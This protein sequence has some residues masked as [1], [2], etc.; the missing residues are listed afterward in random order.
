MTHLKLVVDNT[1]TI[2]APGPYWPVSS[3][4]DMLLAQDCPTCYAEPGEPCFMHARIPCFDR[5]AWHGGD[6]P[7]RFLRRRYHLRR[8]ER[9]R[10]VTGVS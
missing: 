10:H 2:P 8:A 7:P 4:Q 5:P 3:W 9:A 1:P 6:T